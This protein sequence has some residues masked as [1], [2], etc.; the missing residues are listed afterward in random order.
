MTTPS[1]KAFAGVLKGR[2]LAPV[3]VVMGLVLGGCSSANHSLVRSQAASL[4]RVEEVPAAAAWQKAESLAV[5]HE[6]D[7]V[8]RGLGESMRP[9]CGPGT[10]IVVHPTAYFMLRPGMPVVYLNRDGRQVA[11][12]LVEETSAGWLVA[13]LN[14][15]EP[16]TEL[17]TE[18]NLVG[19]IRCAIVPTGTVAAARVAAPPPSGGLIASLY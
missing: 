17:V 11:H 15:R 3:L 14:N 9:Y 18:A 7:F 13:G 5:E 6:G 8:L 19:R 2:I 16:D 1:A 10:L 4:L 12:V